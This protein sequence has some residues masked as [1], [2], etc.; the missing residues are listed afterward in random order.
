[1]IFEAADMMETFGINA[2]LL[3]KVLLTVEEITFSIIFTMGMNFHQKQ[4]LVPKGKW[5][6]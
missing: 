6:W 5:D 4:G 2:L 3:S 1:M